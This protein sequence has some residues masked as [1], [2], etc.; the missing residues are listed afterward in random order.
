[1]STSLTNLVDNLLS[2]ILDY[3]KYDSCDSKLEYIGIRKSYKL[4]F[5]CFKCKRRYLKL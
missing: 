3:G 2:K 4:V 1:M 5:E